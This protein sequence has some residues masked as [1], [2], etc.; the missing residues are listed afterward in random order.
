[1]K[2][3]IEFTNSTRSNEW[4]NPSLITSSIHRISFSSPFIFFQDTMG[5][6][7]SHIVFQPPDP[8]SYDN[9]G[10]LTIS[11]R[12]DRDSFESSVASDEQLEVPVVYIKTERGNTIIGTFFHRR[13]AHFTILFSHVRQNLIF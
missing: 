11:N 6:L 4:I 13:E 12:K 1:M 9:D 3:E 5:I 7:Y 2:K 10:M 8:P